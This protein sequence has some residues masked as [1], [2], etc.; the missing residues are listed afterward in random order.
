M[1]D[2]RLLLLYSTAVIIGGIFLI[3]LTY[4]LARAASAGWYRS[5]LEHIKRMMGAT[6]SNGGDV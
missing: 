4:I 3:I 2:F 5:R 6:H 1:I